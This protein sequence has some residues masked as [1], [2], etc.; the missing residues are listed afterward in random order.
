MLIITLIML[1]CRH[2]D[3]SALLFSA[4]FEAN[5]YATLMPRHMPPFSSFTAP[6][7]AAMSTLRQRPRFGVICRHMLR[8]SVDY[9]YFDAFIS[10]IA[11]KIDYAATP[12]SDDDDD[13][14][15]VA[16]VMPDMLISC[17]MLL[18]LPLCR[19]ARF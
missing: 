15:L 4:I 11:P 16:R 3:I 7:F 8:C 19:F 2:A 1:P 5:I 13:F 14:L 9:A 18:M 17:L 12:L 6:D 10:R